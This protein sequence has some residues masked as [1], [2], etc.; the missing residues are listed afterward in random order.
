M[1][2]RICL[3]TAA[4]LLLLWL[5]FTVGA[6]PAVEQHEQVKSIYKTVT[7]ANGQVVGDPGWE[8]FLDAR[9]YPLPSAAGASFR[10][11]G[12]TL[13][14]YTL[15]S[16]D[17]TLL[18]T[19]R[20]PGRETVHE[21]Y[22]VTNTYQRVRTLQLQ[23]LNAVP[24]P[25]STQRAPTTAAPR[26]SVTTRTTTAPSA[27]ETTVTTTTTAVPTAP[28][29]TAASTAPPKKPAAGEKK[30]PV[31]PIVFGVAAAGIFVLLIVAAWRRFKQP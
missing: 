15:A 13:S 30:S 16:S 7:M 4:L 11:V 8:K 27:T 31:L 24:V 12:S 17:R 25:P 18:Y 28:A 21:Y 26:P 23:P 10:I 20:L 5:P 1:R 6:F 9:Y 3:I 22:L 19:R 29:V 14:D 2:R